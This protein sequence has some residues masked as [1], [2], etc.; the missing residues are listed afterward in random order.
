MLFALCDHM[1]SLADKNG[2]GEEHG[3]G[4]GNVLISWLCHLRTVLKAWT[5]QFSTPQE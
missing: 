1:L 2:V 5:L 4:G 3:R